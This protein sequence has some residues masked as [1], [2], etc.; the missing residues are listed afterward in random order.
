MPF[1][2]TPA[3][4]RIRMVLATAAVE[5]REPGHMDVEQAFLGAVADEEVYMELPEEDKALPKAG[6]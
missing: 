1:S 5:D 4:V 3:A 2:P 6:V